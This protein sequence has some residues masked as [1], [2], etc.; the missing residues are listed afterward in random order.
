MTQFDETQFNICGAKSNMINYKG[1][2][3]SILYP[4]EQIEE[5]IDFNCKN[6]EYYGSWNGCQIM[7]CT[8]CDVSGNG[9]LMKGVE[10]NSQWLHSATNTYLKGVDWDT[11]GDKDLEDSHHIESSALNDVFIIHNIDFKYKIDRTQ[12]PYKCELYAFMGQECVYDYENM[13]CQWDWM[14]EE[15]EADQEDDQDQAQNDPEETVNDDKHYKEWLE[16]TI[17]NHQEE[18]KE[19]EEKQRLF[20]YQMK[21]LEDTTQGTNNPLIVSTYE[22]LNTTTAFIGDEALK[23]GETMLE[24]NVNWENIQQFSDIIEMIPRTIENTFTIN[25]ND[26][27]FILDKSEPSMYVLTLHKKYIDMPPLPVFDDSESESDEEISPDETLEQRDLRNQTG[28]FDWTPS[29]KRLSED[30]CSSFY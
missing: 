12:L 11:I 20:Q 15:Q 29:N 23:L 19:E 21:C 5:D 8:N 17:A 26:N 7:R 25:F 13:D 22:F 4:R 24:N 28:I 1:R 9:A 2:V 30:E 3:F 16:I 10:L 18:E 6:C 27:S 14:D